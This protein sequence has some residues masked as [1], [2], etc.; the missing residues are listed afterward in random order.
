MFH[1]KKKT[2]PFFL[3]YSITY[4]HRHRFPPDFIKKSAQACYIFL[5]VLT[6][7]HRLSVKSE[8]FYIRLDGI[9]F[10]VHLCVQLCDTRT[11]N[12]V[13]LI[14]ITVLI[15]SKIRQ[16][17]IVF[18]YTHSFE[19]YFTKYNVLD[20][21]TRRHGEAQ[22]SNQTLNLHN[23]LYLYVMIDYLLRF[24]LTKN[25]LVLKILTL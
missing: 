18:K 22:T 1:L 6:K 14:S 16:K 2:Y 10:M 21:A 15:F 7:S 13:H 25:G 11:L 20:D 19:E 3:L 8:L 4:K 24:Y 9:I 5:I 12:C 23:L 17:Q